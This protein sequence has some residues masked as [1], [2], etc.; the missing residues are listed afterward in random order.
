MRDL[1][2]FERIPT[3][4]QIAVRI[5]D[6][7]RFRPEPR[8]T[9]LPEI[10]PRSDGYGDLVL[11]EGAAPHRIHPMLVEVTRAL[12][13]GCRLDAAVERAT[14][15]WSGRSRKM[16]DRVVRSYVLQLA[17][18]GIAEIPFE[19]PP[20]VFHGRF[21]RVKTLGRG[22][23]GIA[24][25]CRDRHTG[26]D[27]VVKHAWGWTSSIE[28]ADRVTR[29]ECVALGLV[30]HP[31]IPALIDTFE[32]GGVQHMA[33]EYAAGRPLTSERRRT[34]AMSTTERLRIGRDL[35]DVIRHI[36][37]RGMLYL[38]VKLDNYVLSPE[39]GRAR[40]LD[41]GLCRPYHGEPVQLRSPIGSRGY[42]APEVL[43]G[44]AATPRSDAYGLGRSLYVLAAGERP[45][46]K[47][48]AAMLAERLRDRG[49]DPREASLVTWL[50]AD[51]PA[52]RPATLDEALREL[53]TVVGAEAQRAA[54]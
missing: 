47:W 23:M 4:D 7:K 12:A 5:G 34:P 31:L 50:A 15:L 39:D 51:L 53:D 43:A 18:Q 14:P 3:R 13:E 2:A 25:L 10:R 26:R 11:R 27:V 28:K 24:H 29:T 8:L 54:A 48:N 17:E 42:A 16:V 6:L 52:D 41:L 30:E 19:P 20:D 32:L 35:I 38:D 36:H 1:S 40:L 37:E 9:R 49:I 46:Q 33:R 22:G 45:R 44:R 21:E